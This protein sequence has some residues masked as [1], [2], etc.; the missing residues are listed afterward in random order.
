MHGICSIITCI[1][2]TSVG[3]VEVLHSTQQRTKT[4][5][6]DYGHSL[7]RIIHAAIKQR[8]LGRKLVALYKY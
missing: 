4:S 6:F 1:H 8:F 2:E 3:I 7:P 5:A